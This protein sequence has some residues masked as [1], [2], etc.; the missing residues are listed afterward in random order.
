MP[1]SIR[2]LSV[3]YIALPIFVS[4]SVMTMTLKFEDGVQEHVR[5]LFSRFLPW[6]LRIKV[7][8]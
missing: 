6:I 2:N 5:I 3:L 8:R 7:G 4:A 1:F